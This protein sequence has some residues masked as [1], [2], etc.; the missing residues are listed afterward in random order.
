MLVVGKD[1]DSTFSLCL[2]LS[3]SLS[4]THTL[5]KPDPLQSLTPSCCHSTLLLAASHCQ[6]NFWGSPDYT[7]DKCRVKTSAIVLRQLYQGA[8]QKMQLFLGAAY[9]KLS[10]IIKMTS[11]QLVD[12]KCRSGL[13]FLEI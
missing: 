7:A 1:F 2:S 13:G 4:L 9:L 12:Q 10:D 11:I 3:L 5:T 6:G 8:C